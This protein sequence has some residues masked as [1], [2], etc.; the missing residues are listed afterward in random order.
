MPKIVVYFGSF[1]PIHNNHIRLCQDLLDKKY[2]HV[3][4]VPN[5]NNPLKPYSVSLEDRYQM[6]SLVIG[7]NQ[8]IH[9]YRSEIL[10][11][12]WEG[13]EQ[14]CSLIAKSYDNCELFQVIGQ[15][16]YEKALERCH[17]GEGIYAIHNRKL[18]V[19][20]RVGCAGRIYIPNTMTNQVLIVTDYVEHKCS[21]TNIRD[22]LLIGSPYEVVQD[23]LSKKVYD[24]IMS[25][26]LYEARPNNKKIVI[27]MGS[28]GSGKGTISNALVKQ[29]PKYTHIS[30]GDIYRQAK[31]EQNGAYLQLELD[32]NVSKQ[33][34]MESLNRFII[35]QLKQIIKPDKFYIIDGLK[36]SDLFV[37][38]REI[39]QIDSIVVLNCKYCEAQ[40]RLQLRR[41]HE[42]RPDDTDSIIEKRLNNYYH[43]LWVQKEIL[44]SFSETGRTVVNVS[45]QHSIEYVLQHP[46]WKELF[47]VD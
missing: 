24:Y 4:L 31:K 19:Y 43:F 22:S 15:D 47:D 8:N 39:E 14:V 38:E 7:D 16:S 2:D 36:P 42:N 3:Y 45:T 11:H 25:K 37:F 40:R 44:S 18:I 13:R 33:K 29:Y 34:Y 35:D 10:N 30:A 41:L 26:H 20:P 32:K 5:Q 21:S 28:P 23:N 46:I 17:K 27:I 1:D 6:I 9:L 12:T